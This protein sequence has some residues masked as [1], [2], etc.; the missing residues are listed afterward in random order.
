MCFDQFIL[1]CVQADLEGITRLFDDTAPSL[2]LVDENHKTIFHR[3]A[4]FRIA[5]KFKIALDCASRFVGKEDEGKFLNKL[6]THQDSQGDTVFHILA[7]NGHLEL[8]NHLLKKYIEIQYPHAN[9]AFDIAERNLLQLNI[10]NSKRES[11]LNIIETRLKDYSELER[12]S[13]LT[14]LEY[15]KSFGFSSVHEEI[16]QPDS[17]NENCNLYYYGIWLKAASE[18][19]YP[20][21]S[22][23]LAAANPSRPA[24][25]SDDSLRSAATTYSDLCK[26]R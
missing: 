11:F 18:G 2:D 6:C 14:L 3:L 19:T 8:L 1:A 24:P 5:G 9:M 22:K 23:G 12:Q 17:A 16:K 25:S 13:W 7:A 21:C 15:A 26:N 20:A 10:Y 4:Q